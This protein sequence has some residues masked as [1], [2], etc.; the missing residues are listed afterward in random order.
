MNFIMFPSQTLCYADAPPL[1]LGQQAQHPG[2]VR[3]E[4]GFRDEFEERFGKDDVPILV[5][6]VRVPFRVMDPTQV[7]KMRPRNDVQD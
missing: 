2:V 3:V 1:R 4:V 5:L 7:D 6:I